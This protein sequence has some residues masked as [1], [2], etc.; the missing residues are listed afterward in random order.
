MLPKDRRH[1]LRGCRSRSLEF[2]G[3]PA[4]RSVG[5]SASNSARPTSRPQHLNFL[6]LA[7]AVLRNVRR[8]ALRSP[9]R[10]P[11]SCHEGWQPQNGG[12]DVQLRVAIHHGRFPEWRCRPSTFRGSSAC[13]R[14]RRNIST[15]V[16]GEIKRSRCRDRGTGTSKAAVTAPTHEFAA[17]AAGNQV[18]CQQQVQAVV[19][20]N[21]GEMRVDMGPQSCKA[22][23]STECVGSFR[24]DGHLERHGRLDANWTYR[25]PIAST[26][27]YAEYSV[28]CVPTRP[29]RPIKGPRLRCAKSLTCAKCVP[30]TRAAQAACRML[31]GSLFS[32]I[33]FTA[34]GSTIVPGKN[35][36]ST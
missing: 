33:E 25:L 4:A 29:I 2:A 22:P 12:T 9:S 6:V 36:P 1:D 8:K 34:Y 35:K 31:R 13:C 28:Y 17:Y 19:L 7:S 14:H 24:L 11:R 18:V 20:K 26:R 3:G 30:C 15:L 27:N 32:T 16:S 21:C 23:N 10:R 5:N